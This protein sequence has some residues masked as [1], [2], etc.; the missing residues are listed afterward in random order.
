[1]GYALLIRQRDEI[2]WYRP[3]A[4]RERIISACFARSA[5]MAEQGG[6]DLIRTVLEVADCSQTTS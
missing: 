2:V 3:E 1:M 4:E 5:N 6:F